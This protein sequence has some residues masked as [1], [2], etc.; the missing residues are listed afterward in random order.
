[1]ELDP[2]G[3]GVTQRDVHIFGRYVPERLMTFT[4]SSV[5]ELLVCVGL[6]NM[7]YVVF[8]GKEIILDSDNPEVYCNVSLAYSLATHS[9][10]WHSAE[11]DVINKNFLFLSPLYHFRCAAPVIRCRDS[12]MIQNVIFDENVMSQ[13]CV[14]SHTYANMLL[15]ML[16]GINLRFTCPIKTE[17]ELQFDESVMSTLAWDSSCYS[18]IVN[19]ESGRSCM[20]Y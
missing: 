16:C 11:F 15:H 8:I 1:M 19:L 2:K 4:V 17:M 7:L 14:T 18:E 3:S 20:E 5:T 12:D 10:L 13:R 6:D 9:Y